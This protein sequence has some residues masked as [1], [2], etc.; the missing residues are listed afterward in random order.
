MRSAG[1]W[2]P[3]H[4]RLECTRERSRGRGQCHGPA[5]KSAD[6]CRF[7]I[8]KTVAQARAAALSAWAAIPD[9]DGVTPLAAVAGQLNLSWRRAQLL[10]DELRKQVEATGEYIVAL[11]ELEAAE[12]DRVVRFAAQ[13]HAIGVLDR[14]VNVARAVGG[15]LVQ[16]LDGIF[17][18]LELDARQRALV[19]TVV[20]ARLRALDGGAA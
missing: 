7:H 17:A 19:G 18:D 8:G 20:P 14:Q 16:A 6:A 15:A 10:S 5:V 4:G 11:A 13:A 9:D 2:C 12:R 3:D 1:R